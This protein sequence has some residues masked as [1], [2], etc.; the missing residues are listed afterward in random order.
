MRPRRPDQKGAAG[1]DAGGRAAMEVHRRIAVGR[2]G[3]RLEAGPGRE[4]PARHGGADAPTDW[5]RG[6]PEL[7]FRRGD[8]RGGGG[9]NSGEGEGNGWGFLHWSAIG[10]KGKFPDKERS[11]GVARSELAMAARV[12]AGS[13][14]IG[15]KGRG[16]EGGGGVVCGVHWVEGVLLEEYRARRRLEE[17][18]ARHPPAG[19]RQLEEEERGGPGR[20]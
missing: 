15:S 3:A 7:G 14:V 6:S 17:G 12:G 16:N 18:G 8:I 10:I 11:N 20:R 13:G 2:C 1:V 5:T 19:V 9:R 4:G